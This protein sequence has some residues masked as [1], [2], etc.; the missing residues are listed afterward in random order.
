M[1]RLL[2]SFSILGIILLVL[3]CTS[4]KESSLS[5]NIPEGTVGLVG[6]QYVSFNELKENYISGVTDKKYTQQ[7][8]IDFLP[9]Y[10]DY[11]GKFLDA[12]AIGYFDDDRIKD[13]FQLYLNRQL[14]R[15]GWRKKLNQLNSMNL[16]R[17]IWLN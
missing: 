7:D 13:E 14:M 1:N 5:I 10:L 9:I 3:S 15:S 17:G 11:K 8:L 16:N 2:F 4:T 12:E 6:D